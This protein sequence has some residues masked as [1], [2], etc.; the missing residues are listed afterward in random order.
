MKE[1]T[2]E[3]YLAWVDPWLCELPHRITQ[4]GKVRFLCSMFR[5]Y[6]W[7]L[8]KHALV[9]YLWNDKIQLLDGTHR[10]AAARLAKIDIPIVI[11][12]GAY[13]ETLWGRSGWLDLMKAGDYAL[14]QV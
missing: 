14:V 9:G 6:G 3:C 7:D 13:V 4:P 12:D 8:S 11:F 5:A 1:T 10:A 2:P